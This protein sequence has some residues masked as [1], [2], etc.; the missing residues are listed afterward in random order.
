MPAQKT[1]PVPATAPPATGGKTKSATETKQLRT[2]AAKAGL[3][4][5][6]LFRIG[7]DA[8]LIR[9]SFD[10]FPSAGFIGMTSLVPLVIALRQLMIAFFMANS[11]LRMRTQK[12]V[13][14]GAK[15]AVY[16]AAIMEYL[17]AEVL[18]LAGKFESI[19]YGA[20]P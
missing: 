1:E 10:S 16:V 8:V 13:R 18:E 17:A 12:H 5:S 4:V 7:L 3:Q 9:F 6:T 11:F 20:F 14:I 19:S 15:A 2:R